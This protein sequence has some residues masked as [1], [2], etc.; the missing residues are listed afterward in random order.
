MSIAFT[1]KRTQGTQSLSSDTKDEKYDGAPEVTISETSSAD[2]GL[3]VDEKRFFFQRRAKYD[4]DAIATL[5]CFLLSR[6]NC[7][8]DFYS[9]VYLMTLRRRSST[10]PEMI[11]MP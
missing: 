8:T 9:Q 7:C 5:V 10:N 4:P 6:L 1:R 11:G 2:L 3:A